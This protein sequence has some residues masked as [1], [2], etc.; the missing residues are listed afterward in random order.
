MVTLL[1]S[2]ALAILP[3][4]SAHA[5]DAFTTHTNCVDKAVIKPI[6]RQCFYTFTDAVKYATN[7]EITYA[8]AVSP[9]YGS[10]AWNSL[11]DDMSRQNMYLSAILFSDSFAKG[12]GTLILERGNCTYKN[13]PGTI[14]G[15]MGGVFLNTIFNGYYDNH[16]NSGVGLNNCKLAFYADPYYSG[17]QTSAWPTINVDG[18]P[19]E[20]Q[21]TSVRVWNPNTGGGAGG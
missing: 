3:S 4:G 8:P 9:Q 6:G 1:G 15:D 13:S 14:P 19:L 18:G 17:I 21:T 7:G 10:A 16:V 11:I 5:T 2:S 12:N 20:D